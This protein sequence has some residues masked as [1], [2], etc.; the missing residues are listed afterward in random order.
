M[1][2]AISPGKR[3][4]SSVSAPRSNPFGASS[5]AGIFLT[6]A[7]TG[8]AEMRST[9]AMRFVDTN[10]LLYGLSTDP[11]DSDKS[12][13]A[14]RIL[15]SPDLAMSTQ[16]LQ[17]P[18]PGNDDRTGSARYGRS[19]PMAYLVLGCGSCR[20]SQDPRVHPDPDG[21]AEPRAGLRG[22]DRRQP[23]PVFVTAQMPGSRPAAPAVR[24]PLG[25]A[26]ELPPDLVRNGHPGDRRPGLQEACRSSGSW[27]I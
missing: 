26:R 11:R 16:V 7:A 13:I 24:G 8:L 20:G 27:R 12:V 10:I 15:E 9:I 19:R 6:I 5:P 22:R 1:V 18:G 25:D 14:L 4:S 21:G 3:Q 2:C 23:I 17:I